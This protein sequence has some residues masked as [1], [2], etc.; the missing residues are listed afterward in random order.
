MSLLPLTMSEYYLALL[1]FCFVLFLKIFLMWTIFKSLSNLLQYHF[2]YLCSSSFFFFFSWTQVMWDLK[3]LTGDWTWTSCIGSKI[4]TTR[5]PG[6][7]FHNFIYILSRYSCF[8]IRIIN[9]LS[10]F[11]VIVFPYSEAVW[12]LHQD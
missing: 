7:S 4:L 2:C 8:Y 1:S 5:L 3:S 12:I 10:Y 6:K 11:L 9:I